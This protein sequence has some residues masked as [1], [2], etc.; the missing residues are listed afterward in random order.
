M[1]PQGH[2][3]HYISCRQTAPTRRPQTVWALGRAHTWPAQDTLR[4]LIDGHTRVR[5][6]TVPYIYTYTLRMQ[7]PCGMYTL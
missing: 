1:A 6:L 2:G 7:A 5:Y 3:Y 4:Y